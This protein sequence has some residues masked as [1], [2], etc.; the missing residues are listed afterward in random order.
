M[1]VVVGWLREWA[2]RAR[3]SRHPFPRWSYARARGTYRWVGRTFWFLGL[4]WVASIRRVRRHDDGWLVEGWAYHRGTDVGEDRR[5]RAWLVSGR[6][7]VEVPVETVRDMEAGAT[8][9]AAE[10]DYSL[11]AFR[12]TVPDQVLE[13]W[14]VDRPA[15]LR[16]ELRGADGRVRGDVRSASR[17]ASVP[18]ARMRGTD[19]GIVGPRHNE[20]RLSWWRVTTVVTAREVRWDGSGLTVTLPPDSEVTRPRLEGLEQEPVPLT[21]T[22]QDHGVVLHG[23]IPTWETVTAR[24]AG[25]RRAWTVRVT[26]GG[27]ERPVRIG[28]E[29]TLTV[30]PGVHGWLGVD[31]E[32][33][34]EAV[35]APVRVVVDTVELDLGTRTVQLGGTLSGVDADDASLVLRSRFETVPVELD[36]EEDGRFSA[37]AT[38]ELS[39]WGGPLLPLPRGM[40]ALVAR[41]GGQD[42]PTELVDDVGAD[43]PLVHELPEY[44]L[45][46]GAA[47][48]AQLAVRI[49]PPRTEQEFGSWRQAQLRAT[50]AFGDVEPLDAVFLESF[51]GRNA[52]CNPRAIDAEIARRRPDL[53]R[54]WGVQ[55]LSIEVPEGAVPL[56]R[57]TTEWWRVRNSARWVVTNEWLRGGFAKQPFQTVMQTWHGSMYKQI[58]LD[59]GAKGKSHL[60]TVQ[61]EL[62]KWDMFL[63]QAA[64]TTPIIRRAYGLPENAVIETGYPRN[65]ELH[66]MAESTRAALRERLGLAPDVTVVMYAP[67]WREAAQEDVELLD[68]EALGT[69]LGPSFVLLRRGHVRSLEGSWATHADNVVDVSTYPQVGDLLAVADVLVTD[70]S[71]M[72][73]DFSVTGR[74]MIF[75]TPDIDQYNDP[76]IRGSYFDLEE[77]APGPVTRDAEE[78]VRL[79]RSVADWRDDWTE[80]YDAWRR[81]Y[82]HLD[83]GRASERA[84]DALLGHVPSGSSVPLPAEHTGF[85]DADVEASEESDETE[86]LGGPGHD[87]PKEPER[88]DVGP[89]GAGGATSG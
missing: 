51:F 34:L 57:G 78:V 82:N 30:A 12:I 64:E 9:R 60:I 20:G 19:Q 8:A 1:E 46:V 76:K 28:P 7:R 79:L 21:S 13:T 33:A 15:T 43:L 26:S 2:R 16:V 53:P 31:H 63:S 32:L 25:Q 86:L 68:L 80:R 54:Y 71:S 35:Q 41:I 27:H 47:G 58:G 72:M 81:R 36:R 24:T 22:Q 65:D 89:S 10:H 3:L 55:D 85:E 59:R 42:H 38:L 18:F 84:V 6:R 48:R 56:V 88:E 69:A 49:G 62:N 37:R 17:T 50:Y 73:F 70:Y 83:D 11:N 39:R 40:Y 75:Y 23:A 29:T 67:T 74:P 61:D 4:G 45:R 5:Y 77:R 87:G 52:T 44:R 14:P 66:D